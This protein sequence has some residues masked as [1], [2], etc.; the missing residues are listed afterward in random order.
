M[1]A[2]STV[3]DD[4]VLVFESADEFGH[5]VVVRVGGHVDAVGDVAADVVAVSHI[6][7]G[8]AG[9]FGA[10]EGSEFLA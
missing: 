4:S 6:D 7:D 5:A 9:G 8:E 10:Y 1:L 2:Q 3:E